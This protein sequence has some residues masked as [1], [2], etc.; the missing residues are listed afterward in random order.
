MRDYSISD[1]VRETDAYLVQ[2]SNRHQFTNP[3][4]S[5]IFLKG[6][7]V[8]PNHPRQNVGE[9]KL[10][11]CPASHDVAMEGK[12]PGK[13]TSAD[14]CLFERR[15]AYRV[16]LRTEWALQISRVLNFLIAHTAFASEYIYL[17]PRP[18]F[19]LDR[20]C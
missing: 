7:L 20:I 17:S 13:V 1:D 4:S 2:Q 12:T 5:C 11:A 16:F 6:A 19:Q 14:S 3:S 18:I 15:Q 10:D 9:K 8:S